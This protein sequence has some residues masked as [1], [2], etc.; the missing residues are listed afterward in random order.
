MYKQLRQLAHR[1]EAWSVSTVKELWTRPHLAREMLKYHLS[2]ETEHSSRTIDQIDAIVA[3]IDAQ[4]E[5]SG[6]RVIDLGCGPGLY[7]RRMARRGANVTGVDFSANSLEY[8]RTRSMD[9]LEYRQAYFRE[10]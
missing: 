10:Y 8:A 3:W 1:P 5:L 2:Q 7:A 6:K 9:R 4:L